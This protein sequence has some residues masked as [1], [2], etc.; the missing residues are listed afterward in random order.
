MSATSRSETF[1]LKDG[2]MLGKPYTILAPGS[3]IDS[4]M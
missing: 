4:R 2:M 3:R 1:P